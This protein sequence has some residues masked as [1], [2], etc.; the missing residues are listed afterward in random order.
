[1]ATSFG[2]SECIMNTNPRKL[3]DSH[4]HLDRYLQAGR[5][6]TVL[7]VAAD[8]GVESMIAV[9]TDA[10]DWLLY[11]D[12]ASRFPRRIY[13]TV[14][15]HPCNVNEGWETQVKKIADFFEATPRPVALGEFGLD[16]FH[17]PKDKT[18]AEATI[19]RQKLAFSA[20]LDLAARLE[21]PLVIHSRNAFEDTFAMIDASELD[22]ERVVFHC[23]SGDVEQVKLLNSRGGRA[24]FTGIITYKSAETMRDALKVQGLEKLMIETDAPY[25]APVP[26]RGKENEPGW[27]SYVAEKAAEI[28]DVDI[29]TLA[30]KTTANSLNF[31]RL[32]P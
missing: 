25:L 21:V 31:F 4:C 32:D 10:E 13:H 14:G 2:F 30:Y 22:W 26:H 23:F 8:H 6:D 5:L 18:E 12:L 15:L 11:Q 3:I 7:E 29:E 9:G 27:V 1:M 28:L 20:Q 16:Y 19:A 17:L 24:S